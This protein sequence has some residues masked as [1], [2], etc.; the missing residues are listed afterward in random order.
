MK[1]GVSGGD[2]EDGAM[3]G[4]LQKVKEMAG[5]LVNAVA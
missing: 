2:G 5:T 1:G 3:M 4:V